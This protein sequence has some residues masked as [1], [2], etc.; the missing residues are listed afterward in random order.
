[1]SP[2]VS[3]LS[4]TTVGRSVVSLAT[5]L[6]VE[7]SIVFTE[8]GMRVN[9]SS[10]SSTSNLLVEALPTIAGGSVTALFSGA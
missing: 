3:F 4:S 6:S 10:T 7:L 1:M 5:K 2:S 8:P 9:E